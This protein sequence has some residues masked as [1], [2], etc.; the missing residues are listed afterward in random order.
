M[1]GRPRRATV[2]AAELESGSATQQGHCCCG[3]GWHR[4]DVALELFAWRI[5]VLQGEMLLPVR[6]DP[7]AYVGQD[8]WTQGERSIKENIVFYKDLDEQR[9]QQ[10]LSACGLAIDVQQLAKGDG[11]LA[12]HLSGGQKQRVALCRAVYADAPTYVLDDVL[13]AVD[14]TTAA[15]INQALFSRRKVC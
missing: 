9:Y 13:S 3:R 6:G 2:R 12:K 14:A 8:P 7:I 15:G 1:T 11:T 4:Q 5:V 10:A